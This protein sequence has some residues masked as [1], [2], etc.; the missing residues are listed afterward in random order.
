VTAEEVVYVS[1]MTPKR[2][3]S[4]DRDAPTPAIGSRWV[5]ELRKPHARE[6]IT[7]TAVEWN[8]EEWW[9]C[10]VADGRPRTGPVTRN[11]YGVTPGKPY[12]NDLS[13]FWEA[14]APVAS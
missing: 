6:T 14:V 1:R 5:W 12:W 13:R 8:G 2:V 10:T 11:S 3:N 9:V 4:Y 7:V